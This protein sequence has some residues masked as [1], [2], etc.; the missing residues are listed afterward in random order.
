MRLQG[1]WKWKYNYRA[2]ALAAGAIFLALLMMFPHL[3]LFFKASDQIKY[4]TSRPEAEMP[5]AD[6]DRDGL[7]N[8]LEKRVGTDP[9]DPDTD[10]DGLKDGQEYNFWNER[11]GRIGAGIHDDSENASL[12]WLSSKYPKESPDELARRYRP[13]GDLDGDRLGNIIDPDSDNDGLDDGDE[14]VRGTDPANP[15]SD[16]DGILDGQD[17]DDSQTNDHPPPPPSQTNSSSDYI[18]TSSDF[19]TDKVDRPA[20]KNISDLDTRV[21]FWVEPADK[22]RYWRTATFDRYSDGGWS[23]ASSSRRSYMGEGLALEVPSPGGSTDDRFL[24]RFNGD[25]TGFLPNALHTT[26][27]FEASPSVPVGVD[28]LGNFY[29][30]GV[31]NSY[32]F[33][34]MT[35]PLTAQSLE[36]GRVDPAAAPASLVSLPGTVTARTRD[37]AAALTEGQNTS[38]GKIKA[39]LTH[40]K[41]N[42]VFSSQSPLPPT[43]AEPVDHFLFVSREGTS[44]EFASA[45]VVLC[46]QAEIPARFVTGFAIGDMVDGKRT[47]RAAHYHAWAEVLFSDLGWVQFETTSADNVKSPG[48]VGTD[49]NDPSVGDLE[50]SGGN[51]RLVMGSGGGGAMQNISVTQNVTVQNTSFSILYN[52]TPDI[53]MKGQVFEVKGKLVVPPE[54]GSGAALSVFMNTSDRIVGKG[55]TGPDG[56]FTVICNADNLTVG[57]KKVG[58]NVTTLVR[59]ILYVATTPPQIMK[60]VKLCSNTTVEILCKDYAVRGKELSY[61]VRIDDISG[62]PPPWPERVEVRWNG[63]HQ[64]DLLL[65]EDDVQSFEVLDPPGPYNLSVAFNG[66]TYLY[67]SSASKNISV[68]SSGLKMDVAYF[69][70]GTPDFP[71][72]GGQLFVDVFMWDEWN[73]KVTENITVTLDKEIMVTGTSGTP[74]TMDLD[75]TKVGPG[76][77]KLGVTFAGNAIYPE[78]AKELEVRI[79]GLSTLVLRQQNISVG[80][81]GEV[82]GFLTDNLGF[83][84]IGA[85]V[86][87]CWT[88]TVGYENPTIERFT[89]GDGD[90][91][92]KI[93]TSASTPTGSILVKAAYSGDINYAGSE[94]TTYV[95][96]TSRSYI[97]ATPPADLT[98][99]EAFCV[100][101]YLYDN[102]RRPITRAVVTLR[103][104][105]ASW[106]LGRSDDT[107]NFSLVCEVPG[108]EPT[109]IAPLELGYAGEGFREAVVN[110]YNVSIFTRCHIN[111]TA[112][113]GLQQGGAFDAVAVLTDDRGA[114]VVHENLTVHFAGGAFKARTDAYGRAVVPL[115]FPWLSTREGLTAD[116]RGGEYKRSASA[117]I[118]LKAEPVILY[119]ALAVAAVAAVVAGAYYLYRR[120]SIGRDL[121]G[122][123]AE[124]LDRSWITDRY[125][126]T[127]YKVYTRMLA[128]MKSAGAPRHETWT[129]REY[130]KELA[131]RISLDLHSLGLLT[132]TFEEARY[133]RHLF[134]SQDSQKAVVSYRKLMN[135]IVP[136]QGA[137]RPADAGAAGNNGMSGGGNAGGGGPA[138]GAVAGDRPMGALRNP[139]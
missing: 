23:L 67:A 74:L 31:L 4:D 139:G 15:D 8:N 6:T 118:S 22:P 46:R 53:I 73:H 58:I 96:L 20:F 101:G 28:D 40:L 97:N 2:P 50:L 18:P 64:R 60:P 93:F 138:D 68:K 39:I 94:N 17:S 129:V 133:S 42:Y 48:H 124:L 82:T 111:L 27:L 130:E 122:L 62:L 86:S 104:A 29:T 80:A 135:S 119:R 103:Q 76:V 113:A 117:S 102:L 128:R 13:V 115:R 112:A 54:L 16:G 116:Y 107:G 92:F 114:P 84:I 85:R 108:L 41:S 34:A 134:T 52:V 131:R 55:R 59:G 88:D 57:E 26:R 19:T 61:S 65:T 66:S 75:R 95:Q 99:G 77:H 32:S 106:G 25:G 81:T 132:L 137:Y 90:F 120:Y 36:A 11:A 44:L 91:R 9:L 69:P 70:N 1:K 30:P 79:R 45:F 83:P 5:G 7:F 136:P 78:L 110:H 47:V 71:K 121:E 24:I 89:F 126:R 14:L 49:G 109:G 12:K 3:P 125:R 38:F 43:G 10:A 56:T 105:G 51:V 87:V 98:R 21:L 63:S 127:I 33:D 72:A 35:F 37:L 100:T 123:P